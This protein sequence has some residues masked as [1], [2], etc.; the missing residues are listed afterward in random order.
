MA[1]FT[2]TKTLKWYFTVKCF[3]TMLILINA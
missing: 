1:H 3:S 2:M